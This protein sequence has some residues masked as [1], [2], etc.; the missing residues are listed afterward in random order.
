[1]LYRFSG[2]A[3]NGWLCDIAI[4]ATQQ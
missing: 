1:M 2:F 3:D 4:I